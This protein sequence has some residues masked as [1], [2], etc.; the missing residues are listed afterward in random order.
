MIVFVRDLNFLILNLV[1]I[2][3][4][5]MPP[6]SIPPKQNRFEESL[7]AFENIP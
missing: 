3:I 1:L 5:I 2:S 6:D 4:L 7:G